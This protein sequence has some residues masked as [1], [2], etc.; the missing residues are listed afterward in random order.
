MT[1]TAVNPHACCNGPRPED[2]YAA[3]R[4][5]PHSQAAPHFTNNDRLRWKTDC[6]PPANAP[7][8]T[9]SAG[10]FDNTGSEHATRLAYSS[11]ERQRW[12]GGKGHGV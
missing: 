9:A 12:R 10:K 7:H 3:A 4:P 8:T 11:T 1:Y 6:R 2:A 5:P